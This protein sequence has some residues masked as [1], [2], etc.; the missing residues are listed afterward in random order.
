MVINQQSPPKSKKALA[1][2]LGV[3]RSSLYYK[4]K[5]PEKDLKLKVVFEK[6]MS[7]N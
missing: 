3:S 7:A 1:Q 4:P 5:L 6:V 2:E